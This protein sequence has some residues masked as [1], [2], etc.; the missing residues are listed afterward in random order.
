MMSEMLENRFKTGVYIYR[1][2]VLVNVCLPS[3]WSHLLHDLNNFNNDW[4]LFNAC[5]SE[6][7][8]IIFL[9]RQTV[10]HDSP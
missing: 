2:K 10:S 5:N 6:S 4:Q 3:F 8:H 7:I 1:E 9:L